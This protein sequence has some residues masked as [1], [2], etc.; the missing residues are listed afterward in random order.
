MSQ[1]QRKGSS[2]GGKGARAKQKN[3]ENGNANGNANANGNDNARTIPWNCSGC[4]DVID[5]CAINR[6]PQM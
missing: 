6:M 1:P 3:N 2:S 4:D 5:R